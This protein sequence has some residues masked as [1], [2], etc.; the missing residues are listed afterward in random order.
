MVQSSGSALGLGGDWLVGTLCAHVP[1]LSLDWRGFTPTDT[2]HC[3]STH[4]SIEAWRT[5]FIIFKE[6]CLVTTTGHGSSTLGWVGLS[7]GNDGSLLH[8]PRIVLVRNIL[9]SPNYPKRTVTLNQE[10]LF[11]RRK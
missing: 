1:L 9:W 10:R 8:V 11:W 6:F 4:P 2:V 7:W 5:V 3:T